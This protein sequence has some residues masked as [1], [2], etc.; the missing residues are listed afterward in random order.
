MIS[1]IHRVNF[2]PLAELN[3]LS[4]RA[5]IPF[6]HKT[7]TLPPDEL[8]RVHETLAPWCEKTFGPT[9]WANGESWNWVVLPYRDA[10]GNLEKIEIKFRSPICWLIFARLWFPEQYALEFQIDDVTDESM[11]FYV[12]HQDRKAA[13]QWSFEQFGQPNSNSSRWEC[14]KYHYGGG[15]T[16]ENSHPSS[17]GIV[18]FSNTQDA[19][20]FGLRWL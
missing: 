16:W 13:Y 14:N 4:P 19:T 10:D 17:H 11:E 15:G 12:G 7:F 1:I 20:L 2:G 8:S 3:E 6:R 9:H 5:S 18:S